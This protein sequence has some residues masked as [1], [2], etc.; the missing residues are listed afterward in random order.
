MQYEVHKDIIFGVDARLKILEGVNTLANTVKVTLGPKG[1]NVILEK[2]MGTPH[3]TKDGVSVA[4]EVYLSDKFANLGAQMVREAA[5]KTAEEAGDGTTTSTVLTQALVN[6]GIDIVEQ[7]NVNPYLLQRQMEQALEVVINNLKLKS[8]PI[9][10]QEQLCHVATISANGDTNLGNL[11][12]DAIYQ[13]GKDGIVSVEDSANSTTQVQV[14]PGLRINSGLIS[15]HLVTNKTK[16][17]S[18]LKNP[19]VL[20]V[21]RSVSYLDNLLPIFEQALKEETPVLF[22][23][24]EIQGNAMRDLIKN[25]VSGLLKVAIVTSPSFGDNRKV[26]L[27]DI[28]A[29]TGGKVFGDEH[30]L[31]NVQWEDLGYAESVTATETYT[32]I[33][34]STPDYERVETRL[35]AI[36]EAFDKTVDKDSKDFLKERRARLTGGIAVIKVGGRSEVEIKEKKDRIDDAVSATKAALEEGIV[37]GAGSTLDFIAN[38]LKDEKVC[39]TPGGKLLLESMSVPFKTIIANA[40][41]N[42]DFK[43]I[44]TNKFG[45]GYNCSTNTWGNLIEQGVIDPVKVVRVSLENAVSVAGMILTTDAIVGIDRESIRVEYV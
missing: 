32:T 2:K 3:I 25:H 40:G 42:I 38:Q 26:I 13:I 30:D 4:K 23:V 24:N 14:V 22:I 45:I 37:P 12:S 16:M 5:E 44:K 8:T 41:G 31:L 34:G 1:R 21:E 27:E 43:N 15:P 6:Q 9:L 20:I 11:I 28:A 19:R 36:N 18:E 33:V 35:K 7:D 10:N 17:Q 29:V 39:S